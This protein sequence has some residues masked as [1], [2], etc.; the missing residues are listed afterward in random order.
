MSLSDKCI[1]GDVM[2]IFDR[3]RKRL[4]TGKTKEELKEH[5]DNI[6]LEKGDLT[7]M[8]IAAL[9]TFTPLIIIISLVYIGV[10]F[11]FGM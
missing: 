11:L 6:E 2:S 5:F 3:F 7:A 10:A 1:K 8:L 9:I 4:P